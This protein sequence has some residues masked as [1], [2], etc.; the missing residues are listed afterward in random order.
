MFLQG[1]VYSWQ[2]KWISQL[3]E[4]IFFSIFQKLQFFQSSRKAEI[5]IS[6]FSTRLI[7][8]DFLPSGNSFFWLVL[9]YCYKNN[10]WN[11]YKTVLIETAHSCQLTTDFLASENYF[12]L[13]FSEILASDSFFSHLVEESFATNS[14]IPTSRNRFC[15]QWKQFSFVQRCFFQV[16]TIS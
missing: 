13:H 14:F 12:F 11:K 6:I 7:Q 5:Y 3:V 9:I 8:M 15:G 2:T 16:E 1:E 4:T 10:F